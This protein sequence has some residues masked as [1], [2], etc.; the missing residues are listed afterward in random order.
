MGVVPVNGFGGQEAVL[1]VKYLLFMPLPLA[2]KR[3]P[4]CGWR[5]ALAEANKALANVGP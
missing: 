5:G 1:S 3:R 4:L 2:I